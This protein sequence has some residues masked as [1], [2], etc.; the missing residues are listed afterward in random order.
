MQQT[1]KPYEGLFIT[2]EGG[3]GCGKTSL[4][5]QLASRLTQ[6]G[7]PV[8][9]TREPGGTPL[10]EHIR[11]L[12]LNPPPEMTIHDCTELL[13]FLAA[14]VQHIEETLLPALREGKVVICERFN[15]STIAYQGCAR[16]LGM[17]YVEQMCRLSCQGLEPQCTLLLDLAPEVGLQ[18]V[19]KLRQKEFDRVEQERL[20]FHREVRNGFLHLADCHPTRIHILDASQPL[21]T[22]LELAVQALEPHLMLKPAKS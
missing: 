21:A 8:L 11:H 7:Y 1:H 20:Q 10:S 4:S 19:Q 14:R 18:R 6:K 17:G 3:E 22:V 9:A 13:L 5:A 16:H 12:L 15:D 2:I